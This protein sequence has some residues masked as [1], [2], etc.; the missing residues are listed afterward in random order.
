M[1]LSDFGHRGSDIE[2][3][4]KAIHSG[5]GFGDY[6]AGVTVSYQYD[7]T[8]NRIGGFRH[9]VSVDGKVAVG[10][11]SNFAARQVNGAPIGF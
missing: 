1:A 8:I 6:G 10:V 5:C 4:V 7:R 3:T 2:K 9:N 11:A